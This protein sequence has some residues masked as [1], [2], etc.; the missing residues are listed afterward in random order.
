MQALVLVLV[1]VSSSVAVH[2]PS[3]PRMDCVLKQ[4]SSALR[5]TESRW[6]CAQD[7]EPT[8]I[9]VHADEQQPAVAHQQ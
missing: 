1:L 6:T 3:W 7:G 8:I 4:P 2:S 9:E 5:R